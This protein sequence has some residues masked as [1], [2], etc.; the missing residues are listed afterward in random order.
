MT[1][2]CSTFIFRRSFYGPLLWHQHFLFSSEMCLRAATKF[3]TN[4]HDST[5]SLNCCCLGFNSRGTFVKQVSKRWLCFSWSF[6]GNFLCVCNSFSLCP[7]CCCLGF[8]SLD[9]HVKQV[10]KL[11]ECLLNCLVL[12]V[13]PVFVLVFVIVFV[14]AVVVLGSILWALS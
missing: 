10:F 12:V 4:W 14:S 1:D 5:L 2:F 7:N 8:N 3:C 11:W 9:A 6:I 13:V